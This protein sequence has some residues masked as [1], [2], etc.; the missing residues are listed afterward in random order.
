[1]TIA[2]LKHSKLIRLFMTAFV[3]LAA[4]RYAYCAR[5]HPALL[6]TGT[7]M[8]PTL[9]NGERVQSSLV[10][11]LDSITYG[12]YA[13]EVSPTLMSAD[14]LL[15]LNRERSI[16]IKR[17]IGLPKDNLLCVDGKFMRN[18]VEVKLPTYNPYLN[19]KCQLRADEIYLLGDNPSESYDSRHFGP[20]RINSYTRLFRCI[21]LE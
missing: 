7:S 6:V 4:W 12:V 18:G 17:V 2:S 20:I 9:S 21:D 15:E 1:M 19:F 16:I 11:S 5:Y 14:K 10:R 8:T 13:I 3:L